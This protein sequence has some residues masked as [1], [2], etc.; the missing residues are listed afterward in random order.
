M[1]LSEGEVTAPGDRGASL[2]HRESLGGCSGV[3][4]PVYVEHRGIGVPACGLGHRW[5]VGQHPFEQGHRAS[6]T[7]VVLRPLRGVALFRPAHLRPRIMFAGATFRC[8]AGVRSDGICSPQLPQC[9]RTSLPQRFRR[10]QPR[11]FATF[12]RR[13]GCRKTRRA[14]GALSEG[15]M[16]RQCGEAWPRSNIAITCAFRG[17]AA[18]R[19]LRHDSAGKAARVVGLRVAVVFAASG[20]DSRAPQAFQSRCHRRLV[21]ESRPGASGEDGALGHLTLAQGLDPAQ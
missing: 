19:H 13:I 20:S 10:S 16:R 7:L 12:S 15:V 6:R 2:T 11:A 14:P 21:G 5:L 4:D 17:S 18:L 8:R 3:L 9:R 1:R